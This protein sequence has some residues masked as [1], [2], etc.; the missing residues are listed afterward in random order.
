MHRQGQAQSL[1]V[2]IVGTAGAGKTSLLQ[3]LRQ[4]SKQIQPIFD[5]GNLQSI[6]YYMGASLFLLPVHFNDWRNG[7]RYTLQ[8]IK[9]M[10]RL[11]ASYQIMRQQKSKNGIV[12]VMDQGP[13]YTLARLLDH[14][15]TSTKGAVF[16][17]WWIAMLTKWAN[18]L[19]IIICLDAP[20]DI[21]LQRVYSRSKW[22]SAKAKS[23]QEARDMLA[24]MQK[25]Y[26]ETL[27]SL[28][29]DGQLTLIS[30]DTSFSSVE[31]IAQKTLYTFKLEHSD[32]QQVPSVQ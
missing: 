23:E 6:P 12:T 22:H 28:P 3:A 31:E 8:E 1:L 32:L 5:F 19:D 26:A 29:T 27:A 24:H 4:S 18:T 13:I 2:E 16:M 11:Q 15:C 25:L 7:G 20:V 21:L 30:W 14:Q 17:K 10:I 9:W